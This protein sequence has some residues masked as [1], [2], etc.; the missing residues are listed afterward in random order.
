MSF[1]RQIAKAAVFSS[2]LFFDSA[3]SQPTKPPPGWREVNVTTD[4]EKGWLPT[5]D[6]EKHAEKAARDY[7]AAQDQGKGTVA[8][9][10]LADLNRQ[11]QPQKSY[12]ENLAKFNAESGAV[13]EHRFIK[14]TWTKNPASA[15]LRGVYAAIDIVSRFARIDRHCG[16]L[17]VFQPL[18]GGDFRVMRQES[19][20][21]TN[22]AARGFERQGRGR[23]EQAW[24]SAN[25]FCPN[26]PVPNP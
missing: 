11:S 4:S 2:L 20:H 19:A 25:R 7:L 10:M 17:I 5:V 23:V 26:Y 3:V 15:P 24:A 21:M 8:Y 16:Y 13:L 6:Q 14:T 1:T 18:S 22:E 9:A 12:L